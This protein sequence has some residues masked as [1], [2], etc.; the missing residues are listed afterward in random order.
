M[1]C[2]ESSS[3][4]LRVCGPANMPD[5]VSPV[6]LQVWK[7]HAV[8]LPWWT[9]MIYIITFWSINRRATRRKEI[10]HADSTCKDY[11]EMLYVKDSRKCDAIEQAVLHIVLR[12]STMWI[13]DII[14]YTH[15]FFSS[16]VAALKRIIPMFRTYWN[17]LTCHCI[18]FALLLQ[19]LQK[20]HQGRWSS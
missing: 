14:L 6:I 4:W 15:M 18:L 1:Q 11:L 2:A 19:I 3:G 7:L 8:E 13:D 10:S 20:G 16:C 9:T 5:K 17:T 12:W